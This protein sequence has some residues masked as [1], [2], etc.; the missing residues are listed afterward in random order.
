MKTEL[1]T[2]DQSVLLK[3]YDIVRYVK[4]VEKKC[5]QPG[6]TN[7]FSVWSKK[8][9]CENCISMRAL[10]EKK[11]VMKLEYNNDKIYMITAVPASDSEHEDQVIEL[12][13]DVTNENFMDIKNMGSEEEIQTRINK[14]NQEIILDP[15]TKAYNRRFMDERLPYEFVKSCTSKKPMGFILADI[16]HFK[17]VNDNYGHL[18]GDQVLITFAEIIQAKLRESQD[19][20][21]RYGGEEFLIFISG[22]TEA[23]LVESAEAIRIAVEKWI[24]LHEG[25]EIHLTASFGVHSVVPEQ[26]DDFDKVKAFINNA[27]RALYHSKQ[28]GRNKTTSYPIKD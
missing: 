23:E 13:R 18:A 16:D 26:C 19:W 9:V 12:I 2:L 22:M 21:V 14:L 7:C 10:H 11:V 3:L 1:E 27:D 8:V 24:F 28:T 5:N 6:M 15:L 25:L 4:P 20:I 17:K